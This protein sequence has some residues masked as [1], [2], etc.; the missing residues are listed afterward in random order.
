MT[1]DSDK[2]LAEFNRVIREQ[3]HGSA[4]EMSQISSHRANILSSGGKSHNFP[5]TDTCRLDNGGIASLPE[6]D[7]CRLQTKIVAFVPAAGAS[8]RY[9][10]PLFEILEAARAGDAVAS[11]AAIKKLRETGIADCPLPA[12]LRELVQYLDADERVPSGLFKTVADE[13]DAPKALYPAVTSGESFLEIKRIEHEA[14]GGISGEVFV[15]PPGR[16]GDFKHVASRIRSSQSC[17]FI[18]Q[19]P[20]LATIRFE[21]DGRPALD[22]YGKISMVPSGHGSLL[23]LMPE[24]GQIFAGVDA[25]FIRNIDNVSGNHH[26]AVHATRK[27]LKA[28][29]T[30]FALIKDLRGAIKASDTSEC[31]RL[32]DSILEFWKV[33]RDS[34]KSSL[35]NLLERIF[36]TQAPTGMAERSRLLSRPLVLMGQVPNTANDVGGTCVFTNIDGQPE[37]LCLEVPHA[38]ADDRAHFLENPRLAT[39]F[40][41]VFVVTEIPDM[42]SVDRWAGHPFWLIARKSWNGRDVLYQ[43]SILY[44]MLGNSRYAN[45]IFVEVPRAVFNPH[46]TLKDAGQRGLDYWFK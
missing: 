43:E 35:D 4:I 38:S 30:T 34:G 3:L 28:F 31:E 23:R 46:K 39:H 45:S 19:G 11:K 15:C 8:S 14:I 5:V 12:S 40:N 25:L 29:D 13:I 26:E 32:S 20:S 24:I 36:H 22:K 9:L 10:S 33:R 37:K 44:E 21:P 17:E 41:P 27:F 1:T 18:P 42:S 7:W 6:S 2:N 16:E